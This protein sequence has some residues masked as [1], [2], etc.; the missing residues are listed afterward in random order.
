M[1]SRVSAFFEQLLRFINSE[2]QAEAQH[3]HLIA[4]DVFRRFASD[5]FIAIAAIHTRPPHY[6]G[7]RQTL[8]HHKKINQLAQIAEKNF[9][10]IL[11]KILANTRLASE[12]FHEVVCT[13]FHVSSSLSLIL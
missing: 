13:F 3:D 7:F 12:N 1:E 10:V 5:D 8:S 11:V 2:R 6:L 4:G 9:T